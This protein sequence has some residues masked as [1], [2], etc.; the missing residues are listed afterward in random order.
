MDP[1]IFFFQSFNEH[2]VFSSCQVY[3]EQIQKWKPNQQKP[4]IRKKH[5]QRHMWD[6]THPEAHWE[7]PPATHTHTQNEQVLTIEA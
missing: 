1:T 5:I 6:H 4:S 2:K 3:E 7:K